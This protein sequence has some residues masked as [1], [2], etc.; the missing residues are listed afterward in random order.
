MAN[1]K[2][3]FRPEDRL[4]SLIEENNLFLMVIARFGIP[5]GFGDKTIREACADS[6]ADLASFLA[7]C[8][9]MDGR[10][11]ATAGIALKPLMEFLRSAHSYFLDFQ[12]P[13]IRQKMLQSI[14]TSEIDDVLVQLLGFFDGYCKEVRRHMEHEN[15]EIFPY[16]ER[17]LAGKTDDEFRIVDYS[18]GHTSMAD[19]LD[20][21][22]EVFFRH[23]HRKDNVLLAA[24]LSDIIDC[25]R[26][27]CSHCD[28]EDR[29]FIPAVEELEKSLK[30]RERENL[31][32]KEGAEDCDSLVD[33]M[34]E[35][36]KEIIC[37]VARGMSNKEIAD[38]LYISIN[39]V[40]TYR[41][42]IS[43][44]LQIHSAAGLTIF[45]ILHRLVDINDIDPHD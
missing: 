35:R 6:D 21:L 32:E 13:S 3:S 31:P 26:D 36:E 41:R 15:R 45:A 27:L 18:E 44:K 24:A 14:S 20:D 12:L 16:V 10:P 22:K 33:S 23:Y 2:T 11:Y 40:T 5:F 34:T 7:V 37:C 1:N 38:R 29:L 39:T 28:I 4:R 17:L 25:H 8:N 19:K 30:L 9:F 43:A 42:N